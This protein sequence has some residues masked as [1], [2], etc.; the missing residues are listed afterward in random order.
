[1]IVVAKCAKRVEELVDDDATHEVVGLGIEVPCRTRTTPLPSVLHTRESALP[2]ALSS[3]GIGADALP[4]VVVPALGVLVQH[5]NHRDIYPP[6]PNDWRREAV[7][8]WALAW[9]VEGVSAVLCRLFVVGQEKDAVW[10]VLLVP[11]NETPDLGRRVSWTDVGEKNLNQVGASSFRQQRIGPGEHPSDLT[12]LR[13]TCGA[14]QHC[15]TKAQVCRLRRRLLSRQRHSARNR[16]ND[17]ANASH[18]SEGEL[19]RPLERIDDEAQEANA[20]RPVN[21]PVIV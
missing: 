6:C 3:P 16:D 8:T 7:E 13:W 4:A 1:M 20:I 12:W 11:S 15:N 18:D 14:L 17:R 9:H 19:N 10:Q 2:Q 5:V 21:S